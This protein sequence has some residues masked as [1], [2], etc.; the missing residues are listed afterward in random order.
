MATVQHPMPTRT[1]VHHNFEW[2]WASLSVIIVALVVGAVAGAVFRPAVTAPA[3]PAEVVGLERTQ[4]ATTG[5]VAS[6][7]VT[8]EYFGNSG[9]ITP[10]R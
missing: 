10:D 4:E 2:L 6:P 1:Q 5:M 3:L 9:E 8:G 7:G